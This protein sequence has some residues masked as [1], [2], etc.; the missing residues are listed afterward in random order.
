MQTKDS[1]LSGRKWRQIDV[2]SW[3][4][5]CKVR[6]DK[7]RSLDAFKLY[8]IS[9]H[10]WRRIDSTSE[11][12]SESF[13]ILREHTTRLGAERAGP[14]VFEH[15]PLTRLLGHV[16]TRGNRHSKE[17]QRSWRNCCHFLVQ[18]KG[19]VTKSPEVALCWFQHFSTNRLIT[20]NQKSYSDGENV[21]D[22]SFNAFSPAYS[23]IWYKINCLASIESKL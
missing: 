14:G 5:G 16:A 10:E 12:L 1:C 18:V 17:H 23:Q 9:L 8:P 7:N 11:L 2:R 21:F 3:R 13:K 19:Q 22:G 4:F 15:H 6:V 20:R